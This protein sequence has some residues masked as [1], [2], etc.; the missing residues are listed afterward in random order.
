MTKHAIIAKQNNELGKEFT[1][2]SGELVNLIMTREDVESIPNELRDMI[3]VIK[4]FID[5]ERSRKRG[6]YV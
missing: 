6:I 5:M 1:N 4:I 2:L 3:D